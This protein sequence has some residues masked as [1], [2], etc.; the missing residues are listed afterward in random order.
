MKELSD[1]ELSTLSSSELLE[2]IQQQK[3]SVKQN[4]SPSNNGNVPVQ[5]NQFT[6]QT[7]LHGHND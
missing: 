2:Y 4:K 1:S 5:L 6:I 7:P 3:A